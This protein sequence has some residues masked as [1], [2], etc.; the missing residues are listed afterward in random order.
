M[1]PVPARS[2]AALSELRCKIFGTTYN[3]QNLRTGGKYLRKSLV[4]DA[5]LRYYPANVNL[6][7]LRALNPDIGRLMF[8]E[9]AQRLKDVERKRKLGKGPPKKGA[10][11]GR[12]APLTH[13]R[14]PS[15]YDEGQEEIELYPHNA[16]TDVGLISRW[17]AGLCISFS[18]CCEAAL[19]QGPCRGGSR[20][21]SG[22]PVRGQGPSARARPSIRR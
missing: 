11:R 22:L 2:L 5:M 8:P 3:P 15:R 19:L 12:V 4:G 16:T 9:E 10:C 21:P 14:G 18:A 20:R 6:R 1:P 17:S 13:R 7:S